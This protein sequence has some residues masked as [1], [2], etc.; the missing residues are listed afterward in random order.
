MLF[1]FQYF[2]QPVLNT[3]ENYYVQKARILHYFDSMSQISDDPNAKIPGFGSYSRWMNY[4]ETF[5]PK[6]GD[7][8]EAIQKEIITKHI[9]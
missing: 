1:V 8:E 2:S 3:T 7:F 6:S 5:M 9:F 4:W